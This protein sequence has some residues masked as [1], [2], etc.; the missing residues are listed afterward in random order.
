MLSRITWSSWRN[1]GG[2]T[3]AIL[4]AGLLFLA[5]P[6]GPALA[7]VRTGN[8]AADL[9]VVTVPGYTVSVFAH[10]SGANSQPD[11]VVAADGHLY[12]AYQNKTA[13]DGSDHKSSVIL[14]YR[15]D[16]T[17]D[18]TYSVVGHCDGLRVDPRTH[19]LWALVNNDANP[20]LY[21]INPQTGATTPYQFSGAP[22]GG[23]YDDVAFVG[24]QAFISASNPTLDANG[25]NTF[26]AIDLVTLQGGTALLTP[27]LAGNATALDAAT[28]KTTTLNEVDPDAMSVDAQS[29]VVLVNQGGSE[30]VFLSQ[31]GTAQ[32]AVRRVSVGT[33]LDDTVWAGSG[34]GRLFVVDG[35]QNTIYVV[36][37]QFTAGT[38]YTSTPSDSGVAGIVGSVDLSSGVVSPVATG[39]GSATGLAFVPDDQFGAVPSAGLAPG[40]PTTGMPA[41]RDWAA[42]LGLALVLLLTGARLLR[43]PAR[44]GRSATDPAQ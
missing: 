24:G 9:P 43:T 27:I 32:Q 18:G 11:A 14:A 13:K 29:N 33:Q 31:A 21:T 17:V 19:L 39:F 1:R 2:R 37:A 8:A 25:V 22:H 41:G 35:K 38:A 12:V 36:H 16:G 30:L 3:A 40:M 44:S 42:L 28:Q 23:G 4:V 15:A 6:S 10:G 26:P 7:A 20:L 34:P 5:Q